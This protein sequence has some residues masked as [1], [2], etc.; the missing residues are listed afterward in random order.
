MK[1]EKAKVGRSR[2]KRARD[3]Y[4]V[5]SFYSIFRFYLLALS[6][7]SSFSRICLSP[8]LFLFGLLSSLSSLSPSSFFFRICTHPH[9]FFHRYPFRISCIQCIWYICSFIL[10][11]LPFPFFFLCSSF[12]SSPFRNHPFFLLSYL[13]SV[14][15]KYQPQI[16][17]R[18][19]H[20]ENF[21]CGFR[22]IA[23]SYYLWH[24]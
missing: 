2:Y 16:K 5:P 3:R 17:V 10:L 19:K 23:G 15:H 4:G 22:R 9:L 13:Y 20:T 8:F 12:V 6:Y 18:S 21:W 24:I 14:C 11:S 7:L 1:K